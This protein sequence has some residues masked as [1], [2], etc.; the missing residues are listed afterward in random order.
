MTEIFIGVASFL[1]GSFLT[2]IMFIVSNSNK[3]AL[4][5]SDVGQL[6]MDVK[7]IKERTPT[8]CASHQ[9]LI[10]HAEFNTRRI[11]KLESPWQGQERRKT[12]RVD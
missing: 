3:I 2:A 4:L 10:E 8:V 12:A 7:A 1:G 9:A 11:E 6:K 5:I